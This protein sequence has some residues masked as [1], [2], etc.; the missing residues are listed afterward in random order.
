MTFSYTL[1]VPAGQ[2]GAAELVALAGV[3]GGVTQQFLAQQDPLVLPPIS[4]HL[5]DTDRDGRIGLLELT[6]VIELFNHRSGT[7]RT[8]QYRVQPGTEDGFSPGTE[9][10]VNL[11]LVMDHDSELVVTPAGLYWVHHGGA[12][13]GYYGNDYEIP[14]PVLVDGV[15]WT[16][17]W[18][19][20]GNRAA[21]TSA[22]LP[23]APGRFA[24]W[25]PSFKY[26][27]AFNAYP[28]DYGATTMLNHLSVT[29]GYV[30]E[31]TVN[32][33][34]S[35]RFQDFGNG[36]NVYSVNLRFETGP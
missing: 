9:I 22:V 24:G 26:D 13:P 33:S 30:T 10:I 31:G 35:I 17:I 20:A 8:G 32:G 1:N 3:R 2:T 12:R 29:R 7:V 16:P 14:G 21:G 15:P 23:L 36:Q 27:G 4:G 6:R 11:Q 28:Q 34:P 25:T 5:A 18:N 19:T